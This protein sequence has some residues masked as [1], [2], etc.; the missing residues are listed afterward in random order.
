MTKTTVPARTDTF[1]EEEQDDTPSKEEV[2]DT[3]PEE[4]IAQLIKPTI[5]CSTHP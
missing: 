3:L 1:L 5:V 2:F 4:R